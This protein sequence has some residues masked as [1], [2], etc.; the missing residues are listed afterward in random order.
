MKV[1]I[2]YRSDLGIE[3]IYDS[4]AKA[5]AYKRRHVSGWEIFVI[6]MEVE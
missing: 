3:K 5:L 2:C 4:E 1:W 6:H